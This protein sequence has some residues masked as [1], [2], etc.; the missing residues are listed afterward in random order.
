MV[1]LA[2]CPHTRPGSTP[3]A[4]ADPVASPGGQGSRHLD[5]QNLPEGV[6]GRPSCNME[7]PGQLGA[8]A[9]RLRHP[10][11]GTGA[12]GGDPGRWPW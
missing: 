2:L 5:E 9:R 12:G 6:L 7:D 11:G 1:T 3:G 10:E 8:L 4:G